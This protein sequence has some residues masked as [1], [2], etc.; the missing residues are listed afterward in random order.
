VIAASYNKRSVDLHSC[1]HQNPFIKMVTA[2]PDWAGLAQ[3]L[4]EPSALS[5]GGRRPET[6]WP[7]QEAA[8]KT[9]PVKSRGLLLLLSLSAGQAYSGTVQQ[10]PALPAASAAGSRGYAGGDASRS[11]FSSVDVTSSDEASGSSTVHR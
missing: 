6:L 7:L 3:L 11:G 10:L 1:L 2:E 9:V 5:A 4:S 8:S